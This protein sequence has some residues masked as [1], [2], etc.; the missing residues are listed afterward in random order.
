MSRSVWVCTLLS[1]SPLVKTANVLLQCRYYG[2]EIRLM[3]ALINDR[4]RAEGF[5]NSNC[6]DWQWLK[7]NFIVWLR[8]LQVQGETKSII[9]G[10]SKTMHSDAGYTYVGVTF[11]ETV[12]VVDSF[13]RYCRR[14]INYATAF[15]RIMT[16]SYHAICWLL[17][18]RARWTTV[19]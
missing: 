14:E 13:G 19:L 9:T 1:A 8:R 7:R 15:R 12:V 10:I 3:V 18:R 17:S 5:C 16:E 4:C 6:T 2:T 11:N